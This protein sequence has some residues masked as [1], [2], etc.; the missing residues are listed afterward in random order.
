M[1]ILQQTLP[2][3]ND[4]SPLKRT[5]THLTYTLALTTPSLD[6]YGPPHLLET[7]PHTYQTVFQK[8]PN[9]TDAGPLA[10]LH[11]LSAESA[12]PAGRRCQSALA[13]AL[14]MKER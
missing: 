11:L 2:R 3:S 4:P 10:S 8:H 6:G 5:E 13:V 7:V 12:G 1:N 9:S 14:P